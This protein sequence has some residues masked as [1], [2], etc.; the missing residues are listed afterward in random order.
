MIE[1]KIKKITERALLDKAAITKLV[2]ITKQKVNFYEK[3]VG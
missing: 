1:N 2:K 3:I